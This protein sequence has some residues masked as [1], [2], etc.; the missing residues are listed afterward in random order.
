MG[1]RRDDAKHVQRIRMVW[2]K[3][4]QL[5]I[6]LLRLGDLARLMK[7]NGVG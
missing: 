5:L 4:Q 3:R 7:L 2:L 6:N 1:L